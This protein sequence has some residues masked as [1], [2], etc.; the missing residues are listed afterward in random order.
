MR[1]KAL[2]TVGCCPWILLLVFFCGFYSDKELVPLV[3][4]PRL[5]RPAAVEGSIQQLEVGNP[6]HIY[7]SPIWKRS[8]AR[9]ANLIRKES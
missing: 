4:S 8:A 5:H 9:P 7:P 2:R 1:V 3:M 6:I